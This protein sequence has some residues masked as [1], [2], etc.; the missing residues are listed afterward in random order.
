MLI[1][2]PQLLSKAIPY[3]LPNSIPVIAL[4]NSSVCWPMTEVNHEIYDY[5]WTPVIGEEL[6]YRVNH[7]LKNTAR[8]KLIDNDDSCEDKR[9]DM[10]FN[11]LETNPQVT[12]LVLKTCHYLHQ[13][14][15]QKLVLDQVASA[16]GTN[17]SKLAAEFKYSL[18]KGVF[19]WLR[20]QRLMKA[21][22]LLSHTKMS[23][24]QVSLSVGYENSGNFSTAYKK[25]F[26]LSPKQQVKLMR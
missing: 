17:R 18:G 19:E 12:P 6:I 2:Q 26:S 16:M 23:I 11:S 5:I 4:V 14:I 21:K 1:E 25:Q 13:H 7:A 24:Q 22:H 20:E 15:E 9:L 10:I 8:V 3:P